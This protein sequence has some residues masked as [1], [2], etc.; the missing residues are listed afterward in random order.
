M[1]CN[2]M[3]PDTNMIQEVE[4]GRC[5]SFFGIIGEIHGKTQKNIFHNDEHHMICQFVTRGT[6]FD[7]Q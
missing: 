4:N 2:Q 3:F 7:I 1:V 5:A 6:I